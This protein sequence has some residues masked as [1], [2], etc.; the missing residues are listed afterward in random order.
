MK[1]AKKTKKQKKHLDP[2]ENVLLAI[3]QYSCPFILHTQT[4][5][6][7]QHGCT[8]K[9]AHAKYNSRA[10]QLYREKL[11]GMAAAAQKKYGTEVR[12]LWYISN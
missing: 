4:A 9:E 7:R 1:T 6:F 12:V 3:R 10:A 11:G 2:L 8:T 5:Y